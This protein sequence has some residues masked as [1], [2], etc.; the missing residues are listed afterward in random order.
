MGRIGTS[1]LWVLAGLGR[2][3]VLDA[4]RLV[5]ARVDV[6]RTLRERGV[7][8]VLVR[9]SSPLG[10]H[11]GRDPGWREVTHHRYGSA[12]VRGRD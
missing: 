7:D 6:N 8:C 5:K 12:Y 2:H 10:R 4:D 9:P 1:C 11:L 3:D